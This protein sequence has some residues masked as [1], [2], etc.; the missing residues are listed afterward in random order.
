[1]HKI[2]VL[3]GYGV[4]GGRISERLACIPN[5]ELVIAG[6]NSKKAESFSKTFKNVE[7]KI[8]IEEIDIHNL[9]NG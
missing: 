9:C 7:C 3:G 6:R 1:M 4:F 2:L 5:I 8:S